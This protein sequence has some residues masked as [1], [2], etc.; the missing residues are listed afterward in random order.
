MGTETQAAVYGFTTYKNYLSGLSY[1]M[2][3]LH[4]AYQ[5]IT[6]SLK[7]VQASRDVDVDRIRKLLFNSWNSESLLNLPKFLDTD[8]I[9]FSNHWSPV[10]S[11]YALY[12][13]A[14]GLIVAR[15]MDAG[16]TH[17]KTLNICAHN[18]IDQKLFP[19][20]WN[21]L[22][23][24]RGVFKNLP[25]DL[26][27]LVINSQENPFFFKKDRD[28]LICNYR[29]FL[30]TTRD[31][32]VDE[33]AEEWKE[34]HPTPAGTRLR[35]PSGKRDEI[36]TSMRDVSFLDCFYRLRTRSNYK[37]VDIFILGSSERDSVNYLESLCNVTDKTLFIFESYIAR[38]IGRKEMLGLIEQYKTATNIDFVSNGVVGVTK[39][40]NFI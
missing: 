25:R 9:K 22:S 6:S 20:P 28:R 14:R 34:G 36:D 37:D 31:R 10:Q 8:F 24:G 33:K 23:G 4:P 26:I 29:Q 18:F 11:Y 16:R 3:L 27:E 40:F 15:R 13:A 19:A 38:S 17:E 5:S 21:Y 7:E 30:K 12:L 35:L 32:M 2:D 39:R 1:L